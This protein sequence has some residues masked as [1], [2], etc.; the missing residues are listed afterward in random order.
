MRIIISRLD[1]PHITR[2][3]NPALLIKITKMNT[4][5]INKYNTPG[6]RYTSYP[7]VP[8][9]ET[10]LFSTNQFKD[11]VKN[12]FDNNGGELSLYLHLPFCESLCTYCGCTTRITKQHSVET[13][14]IQA[15]L[16]EWDQYLSLFKK[17]PIIKSIHLGGGT[18]TFFSPENLNFLLTSLMKFSQL[19][20]DAELSF[21]AHPDSTSELH[22]RLLYKIGF[23]RVSFGIQDFNERV[24]KLINRKQ[25]IQQIKEI[26]A[27][28]RKIGYTS[29]NYDLIYGLPGQTICSVKSTLEQTIALKPDR[30]AYY[31]YAHV[32]HLKPAQ[33]SFEKQLP[34]DVMKNDF[35]KMG[36]ELLSSSGYLDIG[37][38]HFAKEDDELAIAFNNGQLHRNFMGYAVQHSDLLIGLGASA[39]SD[40]WTAFAQN[41]KSIEEYIKQVSDYQL[42][43]FR[44]HLLTYEDLLLRRQILN[45]ICKF[46]TTWTAEEAEIINSVIDENK[47]VEFQNDGL[48]N[49]LERSITVPPKGRQFIRNICMVFDAKLNVTREKMP[50]FSKTI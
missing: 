50:V 18:P 35:Y 27:L 22:L 30:I 32:P 48:I 46:Q 17:R 26:T 1:L 23:R 34:I 13:A 41:T 39:I 20:Q 8:Y 14:Y 38:D 24:Q 25:S 9:W 12:Q 43:I 2:D 33:K 6:P 4:S 40:A 11:A 21:E 31:S 28:A 7:T 10:S 16:I 29:I 42:P 45:L 36:K 3:W 37:M 19:A 15:L 49:I 47:L 5:L 44:G